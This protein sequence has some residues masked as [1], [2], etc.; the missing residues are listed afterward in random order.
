MSAR[1]AG[2]E[3]DLCSAE[4]SASAS[5]G[6]AYEWFQFHDMSERTES[7]SKRCAQLK[8]APQVTPHIIN[9]VSML[10]M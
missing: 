7:F 10:I 5:S 4:E 6:N 3:W 2:F 1:Y 8:N 9:Y